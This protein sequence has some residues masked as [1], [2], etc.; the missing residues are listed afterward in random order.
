MPSNKELD[1]KLTSFVETLKNRKS[2]SEQEHIAQSR[3]L[4]SI[5]SYA[6]PQVNASAN[7]EKKGWIDKMRSTISPSGSP[8][9]K[10]QLA[11]GAFASITVASVVSVSLYLG[12][13]AQSPA[14]ATVV[15]N[16]RQIDSMIYQ[17]QMSSNGQA[18][19]SLDVYYQAPNKL[20]I[21]NTPLIGQAGDGDAEALVV[22]IL[23]TEKGQG[24]ILMPMN[25]TAMP[26]SF[27][28][29]R[30]N[31]KPAENPLLWLDV[32][33]N[34]KGDVSILEPNEV[35]GIAAIGYQFTEA[36]ITVTMWVD[37][38]SEIPVSIK[39]RSEEVNG[40]SAFEL[41]GQ[42]FFNEHIDDSLFDLQ[43]GPEYKAVSEE[44]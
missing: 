2:A 36:G 42:V 43:L 22:N 5:N 29:D 26:F 6:E 41:D 33:K 13:A 37:E 17:A 28:V 3:L 4:H 12:S 14:F 1:E 11:I 23:D 44:E 32:V 25:K 35:N 16:L 27:S 30:L 19:M 24:V 21:E 38:R 8:F 10:T 34:Y 39:V 18:I 9:K 7:K 40:Q 15:A 31:D 20:R